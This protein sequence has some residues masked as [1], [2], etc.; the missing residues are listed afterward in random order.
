MN[1]TPLPDAKSAES[2]EAAP[3]PPRQAG[4]GPGGAPVIEGTQ[5][6]AEPPPSQP[7][8]SQAAT[9]SDGASPPAV[10]QG[11]ASVVDLQEATRA[12]DLYKETLF[13]LPHV[14]KP[15]NR[16]T[17]PPAR[18]FFEACT[19][20]FSVARRDE[21]L[22]YDDLVAKY[23][24]LWTVLAR[25]EGRNYSLQAL[26]GLQLLMKGNFRTSAKIFSEIEFQ[27]STPAALS[28]VMHGIL[29]F[30]RTFFIVGGL[31]AYSLLALYNLRTSPG[32]EG[33]FFS[34]FF[35]DVSGNI[36][37]ATICGMLGS[38]VSLLLRLSEFETTKGRS[39]MF[40]F[41]T[42]LTLPFIGGAFG[43]FIAALLS[44]QLIN[45]SVGTNGAGGGMNIWVYVAIGFLSGF[46]E[47]F[48]RSFVQ[49]AEERLGGTGR[50]DTVF[51]PADGMETNDTKLKVVGTIRRGPVSD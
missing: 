51:R 34:T 10:F 43:A 5:P 2:G 49:I 9:G 22:S 19:R 13:T 32:Q 39:Q 1:S 20:L 17:G 47:R 40:L 4:T 48:S 15:Q 41:L 26:L 42:G 31:L 50:Q 46:S 36:L 16:E 7:L 30:L 38:V 18:R 33:K 11:T 45:I 6:P 25:P 12:F 23:V 14:D 27:T 8:P 3:P 21:V 35:G 44:A 24:G 28:Y 37:V 29:A